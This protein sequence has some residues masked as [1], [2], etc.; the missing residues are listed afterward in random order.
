MIKIA[1]SI[2]ASDFS[3]LGEEISRVER[4]GADMIHLDVMDGHFVPNITIGPLVIKSLRKVTELPFDVH[5]MIEEP[6]RY[7]SDFVDAGANI[8]SVH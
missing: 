4:A 5:L 2:L 1:P 7:I 3:R 8:I 6:D